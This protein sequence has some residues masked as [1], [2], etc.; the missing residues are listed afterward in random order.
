MAATF[1]GEE[2]VPPSVIVLA[3]VSDGERRRGGREL[4]PLLRVFRRLRLVI[5]REDRY[6]YYSSGKV[7]VKVRGNGPATVDFAACAD[8]RGVSGAG[9]VNRLRERGRPGRFRCR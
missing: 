9:G 1:S 2:G 4:K 7:C 5:L 6:I 8:N 3:H